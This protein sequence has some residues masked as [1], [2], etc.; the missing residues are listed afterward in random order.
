MSIDI[1]SRDDSIEQA[2]GFDID[3]CIRSTIMRIHR[4]LEHPGTI[5]DIYYPI[6]RTADNLIVA[7][8]ERTDCSGMRFQALDAL[9]VMAAI[10]TARS[11]LWDW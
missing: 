1:L 7:D 3:D 6:V 10:A 2:E 4:S 9:P 11:G 5:P 8:A